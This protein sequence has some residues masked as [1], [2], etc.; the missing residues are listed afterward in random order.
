[1][2]KVCIIFSL[3]SLIGYAGRLQACMSNLK[4]RATCKAFV[5][6]VYS[7]QNSSTLHA[8]TKKNFFPALQSS[9]SQMDDHKVARCMHVEGSGVSSFT[10]N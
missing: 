5:K 10:L 8:K 1:M 4:T 2:A 9:K 3:P 6:K 7:F